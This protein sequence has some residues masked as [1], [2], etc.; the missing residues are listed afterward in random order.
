[1]DLEKH[2]I[3]KEHGLSFNFDRR[4]YL[5]LGKKIAFSEE[6]VAD[7][8]LD[9]ILSTI[10]S[11]SIQPQWR[12]FFTSPPTASVKEELNRILG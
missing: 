9:T 11:E 12:F 8:P 10:K 3:L 1:M 4:M 6:Y 7:N 5:D 2:R